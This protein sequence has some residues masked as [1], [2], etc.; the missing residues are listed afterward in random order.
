MKRVVLVFPDATKMTEFL[1]TCRI[2]GAE[3]NSIENSLSGILSEQQIQ[4]A[5]ETY[6]ARIKLSYSVAR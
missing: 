2:A 6:E 5:C 3:I 4:T 1:L